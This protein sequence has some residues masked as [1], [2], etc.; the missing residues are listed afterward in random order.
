M[1]F[2]SSKEIEVAPDS[3]KNELLSEVKRRTEEWVANVARE[4]VEGWFREVLREEQEA[5][6][7]EEANADNNADPSWCPMKI[8]QYGFNS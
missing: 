3:S 5:R 4:M 6:E 2:L 8:S 1:E 7:E